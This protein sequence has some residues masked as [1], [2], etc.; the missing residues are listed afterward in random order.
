MGRYQAC[1]S[2]AAPGILAV[3]NWSELL[4]SIH[5]YTWNGSITNSMQ[6]EVPQISRK[7]KWFRGEKGKSFPG[8]ACGLEYAWTL[9]RVRGRLTEDFWVL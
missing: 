2:R 8:E 1:S 6:M 3:E 9:S 7:W 5:L 4:C